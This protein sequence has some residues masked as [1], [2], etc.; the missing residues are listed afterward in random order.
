MKKIVS[1][2]LF[3]FILIV[4]TLTYATDVPNN[5]YAFNVNYQGEIKK[6]VQKEGTVTL[7][8]TDATPYTNVRIKID[9]LSGPATPEILATDSAGTTYNLAQIGYWGPPSGFAV[10]GTFTNETPIKATYPE[11]G[12]YVTKLSLIDLNNN[13]TVITSKE[14]SVTVTDENQ[15]VQNVTNN[16]IEEIP[17]TGVSIW[18]YIIVAIA[19]IVAILYVRKLINKSK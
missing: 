1:F 18:T 5:G 3:I 16:A 12:T 10:G 19:L 14:F 2:A 7:T 4:A 13:N 9:L 15:A 8:G 17:Q 11:A 6:N